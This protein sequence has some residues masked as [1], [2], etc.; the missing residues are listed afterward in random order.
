MGV[1]IDVFGGPD[2]SDEYLA[3]LKLKEIIH[4][5]LPENVEGEIILFASAT[6]YGQAVKDVDLFMLGMLSNYKVKATFVDKD[7]NLVVDKVA[8]KSFCTT[9]EV[10]KHDISGIRLQGTNFLVKYNK[11][12]HNVTYQSNNQKTSAFNFF[13]RSLGFSPF[14]T[15]VIW[16]TQAPND[17]IKKILTNNGKRM[18]SNVLGA[19]FSLKE[20]MQIIINQKL[21][22]YTRGEYVWES[23]Y[24]GSSIG[25]FKDALNL[26][27]QSKIQMGELTRRRIEQI[28]NKEFHNN[29]LFDTPGK[30]SIYRGR[31]GTGKTV[32]LIQTAI[33]LVDEE[34]ARV[35][36]LTYNKALVSDIRRLFALTELP[37]M[38]E[39]NCVHICTMHSYFRN[40]TN[41]LLYDGK[42]HSDKFLDNYK[43]IMEELRDFLNDDIAIKLAHELIDNDV[44]LS[45]D[46]V[47]IDEAQD[48]SICERDVILRLFEK[49]KI[50]VADGGN[51]FVRNIDTCDWSIVRERNNIKLKYC[52]RQ[53][54]NLITF[55]NK[56]TQK[57]NIFGGKI[58]SNNNMLGGKVII[59][60]DKN[61]FSVH[62]TEME[63][64]K[65]AGNIAYDMLYLVPHSLVK[66][67]YGNSHF[68]YTQLFE[69]NGIFIWD[70]TS[71]DN[72][73][74][75][76][77]YDDEVRVLQYDSSRGLEGWTVICLDFDVFIDE[78][79]EEYIEGE[80]ES[81]LLE[82]PEERRKKYI[83]NWAMMPFTRAID[84]LVI[85]LKNKD[86]EIAKM[87]ME[88]AEENSD[89][90]AVI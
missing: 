17:D 71:A 15:N 45:W 64:L 27:S 13:N 86:S 67:E 84:T 81:L 77:V 48:W 39:T 1:K 68:A 24:E 79:C 32:G 8:V 72:R 4:R 73:D 80:T 65:S 26:F 43:A 41:T 3:A 36:I 40:L 29:L 33:R 75:Y 25:K 7:S 19:D 89:F 14:V 57:Y 60:D 49:G 88:I 85:T 37:D 56:F 9:I 42:M 35:L 53:K 5:D 2:D 11:D 55:L 61:L 62:R 47:L 82:S 31:A 10:K 90:I 66:K 51:Q 12:W 50:I 83:Y 6:L 44:Q 52:L 69:Q 76:S 22:Y 74:T 20:L 59:T 46:Y 78:K 63:R 28:T 16:F 87:L 34:L 23:N 30:I 70:G 38:F 54:E 21:P 58:L 18:P